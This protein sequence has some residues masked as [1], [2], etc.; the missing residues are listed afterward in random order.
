MGARRGN[1]AGCVGFEEGGGSGK[2]AWQCREVRES[3]DGL[4]CT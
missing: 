3:K 4:R 1:R 2:Q